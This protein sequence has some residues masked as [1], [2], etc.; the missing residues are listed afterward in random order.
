MTSLEE[1]LANDSDDALHRRR[2]NAHRIATDQADTPMGE[3]AKMH[4][5]LIEAEFERRSL[6]GNI[7]SFLEAF[8][9]GFKDPKHFDQERDY[10]NKARDYC[11]EHLGKAQFDAVA[12]GG[13]TAEL[14]SHVCKL[15]A[16]TNL[17][18]GNFEK[19]QLID[20]ISKPNVTT[21]FLISLGE[22]L[23][24]EGEP[25]SRIDAF[26]DA[27]ANAGL[28]RKWTYATYFLFLA[29]PENCVFVKPDG[30]KNALKTTNYAL[31]YESTASTKHYREILKFANWLKERLIAQAKPELRPDGMID[32]QSFMW[33][34]AP[35]GKWAR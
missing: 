28:S 29:D 6:P 26:A 20:A 19:P 35:T 34:M 7:N 12:A 9:L 2:V 32:V 16:K 24:G 1:K 5:R 22:L 14:L 3:K 11:H 30:L 17:I 4:L 25:A 21:A 10:K 13:D 18:Q 33:H 31:T 15:V 23:H 8:P 27:L